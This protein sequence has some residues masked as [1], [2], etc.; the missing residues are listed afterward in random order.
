VAVNI[1]GEHAAEFEAEVRRR[2]AQGLTVLALI[3]VVIYPP[4][5]VIDYVL[6]PDHYA[7]LSLVRFSVSGLLAVFWVVLWLMR[8]RGLDVRHS[9][10]LTWVFLAIVCVSLDLFA[11]VVGGADTPYYAGITLLLIAVL[12]A[13]PWDVRE[14]GLNLLGIVVQ[15]DVVTWALDEHVDAQLFATSNYFFAATMA[16]GLIWSWTGY[17]L[18]VA[19]FVARKQ[20]EK[21]KARSEELLLNILPAE[22]AE[23]LKAHG[24][25]EARHIDS[26]TILFTDFVGFTGISGRVPAGALVASLDRA[27]SRFDDVISRWRLEKLKTIGDAYMCAGGVIGE[28]PDHL[29]ACLLAGLEMLRVVEAENLLA[30]DGSRWRMRIGV[31]TGPVVAGVIGQ[32]KFAFDLWGDTVNT[33]SRL[34]SA[35]EP[36]SINVQTAVY[37]RVERF[38]AGVDRGYI[39]VR[40]KGPVAMTKLTRLRPQYSADAQGRVPSGALFADVED[41]VQRYGRTDTRERYVNVAAVQGLPGL[42]GAVDPLR[43]FTQLTDADREG[44][45]RLARRVEFRAGQVIIEEGQGLSMLFLVLEGLVGV[46][47]SRLGVELEVAVLGPGEVVGEASFVTLEPASA[48]VVALEDGLALRFDLSEIQEMTSEVPGTAAR[49]L[50]SLALVLA[51]R[52]RHANARL[53]TLGYATS[54][55]GADGDGA[56]AEVPGAIRERVVA[57]TRAMHGLAARTEAGE[58]VNEEVAKACDALFDALEAAP[59]DP[60]APA[61]AAGAFVLRETY[62]WFMRSPVISRAYDRAPRRVCDHL[63]ADLIF[64]DL[65]GGRATLA[66]D[67]DAWFLGQPL[68]VALRECRRHVTRTLI[69]AWRT[70][71]QVERIFRVAS[72][73]APSASDLFDVLRAL[74]RPGDLAFCYVSEDLEAITMAGRRAQAEELDGYFTFVREFVLRTGPLRSPVKLPPQDVVYVQWLTETLDDDA[75][76]SLINE[77]YDLVRPGGF[78]LLGHLNLPARGRFFTERFLGWRIP[79]RSADDLSAI[80]ARSLFRPDTTTRHVGPT[81]HWSFLSMRRPV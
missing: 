21:E 51:H 26:S 36:G 8:R 52:L 15:F 75:L 45:G 66:P 9:R 60:T 49:L 43:F 67:V 30:A 13:M 58:R 12:V 20:V 28:R 40:G 6:W 80:A 16:I 64:E 41:W 46:R 79:H 62:P 11:L 31:H 71:G 37:E 73:D 19:E 81:G 29:L 22:V 74:E 24:R 70:R 50:H 18:R 4:S 39:P 10:P 65:P 7:A 53:F 32:K 61:P 42:D 77:A 55:R 69:D 2:T 63:T 33:A 38:F 54:A 57:F 68:A 14:M 1:P 17:R 27:F 56:A 3:A 59:V 76:L 25:V 72:L 34:E 5:T 78:F 48:T 23:E 44:L 35:A 47:L